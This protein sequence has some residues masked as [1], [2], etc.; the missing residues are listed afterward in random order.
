[1][2]IFLW[3]IIAGLTAAVTFVF[4]IKHMAIANKYEAETKLIMV[5]VKKSEHDLMESVEYYAAAVKAQAESAITGFGRNAAE[6][7][8]SVGKEVKA[9][10]EKVGA[11]VKE[12]VSEVKS[13]L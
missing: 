2:D 8:E 5:Q 13:V 1:M 4:L 3:V 6:F 11:G 12:V 10:E 9:A 7:Y